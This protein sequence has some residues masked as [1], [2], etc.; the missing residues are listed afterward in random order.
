MHRKCCHR[1]PNYFQSILKN[2]HVC[3][4][5][6]TVKLKGFCLFFFVISF[7]ATLLCEHEDYPKLRRARVKHT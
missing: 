1:N 5:Q 2:L 6:G 7:N 3:V 4:L